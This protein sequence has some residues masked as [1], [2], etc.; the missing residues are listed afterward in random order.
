MVQRP[1]KKEAGGCQDVFVYHNT[2]FG[3][4]EKEVE[5]DS[6]RVSVGESS[7]SVALGRVV[8]GLSTSIYIDGRAL[9]SAS[10]E[11]L[12]LGFGCVVRICWS[13]GTT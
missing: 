12:L 5:C 10:E 7:L 3:K 2:N 8:R 6:L 9:N 13:M 11:N 4:G 1:R